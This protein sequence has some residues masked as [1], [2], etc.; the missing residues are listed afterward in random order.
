M[1]PGALDIRLIH[2]T[3]WV[4]RG[5]DG[6]V[7]NDWTEKGQTWAQRR[8]LKG[9]T[10]AEGDETKDREQRLA[11]FRVRRQPFLSRYVN[12]DRFRETGI[13]N[14]PEATWRILTWI[15]V[16]GGRSEYLD[17]SCEAFTE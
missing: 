6:S 1:N 8:R 11:T 14:L 13:N 3:R 2:E 9:G 5:P 10:A 15:E 16:S 4:S 17:V 12:G 7:S